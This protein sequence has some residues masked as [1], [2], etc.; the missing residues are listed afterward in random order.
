MNYRMNYRIDHFFKRMV[1]IE[2]I[3]SYMAWEQ[4]PGFRKEKDRFEMY[5]PPEWTRDL[6]MIFDVRR[7][8]SDE[9]RNAP[10]P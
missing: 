4:A 9:I 2:T 7:I 10:V 6:G 8:C 5:V 1:K 3:I